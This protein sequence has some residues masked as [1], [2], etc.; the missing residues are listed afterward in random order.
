MRA[1]VG[2]AQHMEER[3]QERSRQQQ[4][5]DSTCAD[6][7]RKA[8]AIAAG[9]LHDAQQRP[10]TGEKPVEIC[11][12]GEPC[13][14]RERHCDRRHHPAAA[15]SQP[16]PALHRMPLHLDAEQQHR[17]ERD[18]HHRTVA[19]PRECAIDGKQCRA[20]PG[21]RT[22]ERHL[23][24]QRIGRKC[25]DLLQREEDQQGSVAQREQQHSGKPTPSN[26]FHQGMRPACHCVAA[27]CPSASVVRP[28][29]A[30]RFVDPGSGPGTRSVPSPLSV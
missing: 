3:N 5:G 11:R 15:R 10:G 26:G 23:P 25:G 17:Q 28:T 9:A 16:R 20:G 13:V 22:G 4:A 19:K 2:D 6:P 8:D 1:D 27:R 7:Q 29:F 24:Q 12:L 30:S 18:R 14:E 21:R